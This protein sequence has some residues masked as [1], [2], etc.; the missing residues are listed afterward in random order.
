MKCLEPGCEKTAT[1]CGLCKFHWMK[2]CQP[3]ETE[4]IEYDKGKK[5]VKK[6]Y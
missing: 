2:I 6:M 4:T 1:H 3:D 5:Y